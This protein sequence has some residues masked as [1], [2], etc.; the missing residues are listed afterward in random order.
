MSKLTIDKRQLTTFGAI[1][2]KTPGMKI[3]LILI[4]TNGLYEMITDKKRYFARWGES[5]SQLIVLTESK[6][7]ESG[8]YDAII[9]L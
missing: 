6:K 8:G 9:V 1:R 2:R 4:L 3:L 5:W 7:N